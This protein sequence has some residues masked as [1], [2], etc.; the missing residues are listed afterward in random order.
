M[1]GTGHRFGPSG[2]AAATSAA[3]EHGLRSN[4]GLGQALQEQH[5]A[6]GLRNSRAP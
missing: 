2:F 3:P 4:P 1:T 5:G 6:S